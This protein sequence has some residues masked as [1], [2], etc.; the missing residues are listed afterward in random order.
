[1]FEGLPD[2]DAIFTPEV[3]YKLTYHAL[4]FLGSTYLYLALKGEIRAKADPN[5]F[6]NADWSMF[7]VQAWI[8]EN[9]VFVVAYALSVIYGRSEFGRFSSLLL[10]TDIVMSF[11]FIPIQTVRNHRCVETSDVILRL[12]RNTMA[13]VSLATYQAFYVEDKVLSFLDIVHVTVGVLFFFYGMKKRL[14]N[15]EL[16]QHFPFNNDPRIMG[17]PDFEFVTSPDH[18][19]ELLQWVAFHV[20]CGNT[21]SLGFAI[22]K[23][24]TAVGDAYLRHTYADVKRLRGLTDHLFDNC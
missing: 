2:W 3:F 6:Y 13:A 20:I 12:L 18:F 22:Y 8:T 5:A 21:T 1:M 24:T 9:S 15:Y 17:A 11:A 16:I 23:V 4:V 14:A 7:M 10:F 19:G